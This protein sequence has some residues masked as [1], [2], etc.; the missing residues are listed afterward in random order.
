MT[1]LLEIEKSME[2]LLKAIQEDKNLL[3]G[4]TMERVNQRRKRIGLDP[5]VP[6]DLEHEY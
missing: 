2:R 6:I 1:F 5:I 3:I 4:P